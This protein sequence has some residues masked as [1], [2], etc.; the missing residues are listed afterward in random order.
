[1]IGIQTKA[2]FKPNTLK[3]ALERAGIKGFQMNRLSVTMTA[4]KLDKK[5]F[6]KA[7]EIIDSIPTAK[8]QMAKEGIN[9]GKP[10]FQDTPNEFAYLDF[11][12]WA[13][14]KRGMIKKALLKALGNRQ[15]GTKMFIALCDIWKTWSKAH[16]KE[17]SYV[18]STNVAKKDFGRALAV[19]MKKDNLI[20]T[21]STNKLTD[22]TEA[23]SLWKMFDAK[24]KLQDEIMD[25]EYDMKM[26]TKDIGQ[27]HKDMEQE[28]EPE[29]GPKA[30]RYGREITKLEKS[31][32]QKKAE[33][34]KQMAKLD[35]LEQ[36]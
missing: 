33:F 1:M 5:D 15:D 31:Y 14:K 23:T 11:K 21:K 24:M 34:K 29:G 8:I 3:G 12:K 9:E 22:L 2:N 26:I 6:E 4:L 7:K 20:I 10:M 13:Y 25:L 35:R 32:K 18:H 27:L 28:A 19:M 17:W 30:T 16:A 36:F